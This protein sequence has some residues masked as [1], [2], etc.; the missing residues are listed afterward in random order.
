MVRVPSFQRVNWTGK[1]PFEVHEMRVK[2]DGFELT[3]TQPANEKSL[4]MYLPTPWNHTPTFIKKDMVAPVDKTEPVISKAIPE[5]SGKSVRLIVDGMVKGNV[6]ELKCW[7]FASK[8]STIS[9]A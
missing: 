3:F 8:D 7:E 5:K 9:S 6:H 4:A 2:P 1:V